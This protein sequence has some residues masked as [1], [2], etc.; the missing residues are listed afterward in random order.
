MR[1]TAISLGL[2][3]ALASGALA[4]T[5]LSADQILL[6]R[7]KERMRQNLQR[8]PNYTCVE[9]IQRSKRQ[10]WPR[11]LSF[12]DSL[13][14]EV[15]L[16]DGKELFSWPGTGQFE[17]KGLGELV[18]SG[19]TT[20]GDFALHARTVFFSE[21]PTFQYAGEESMASRRAVRF[22][23]RVSSLIS[24]YRIQIGDRGAVAGSFGSFWADRESLDLIR[25]DVHADELPAD[26][27]VAEATTEVEYGRVQV[28]D[29]DFL[30]PKTVQFVLRHDSG[31]ESRNRTAFSG[32][33]QYVAQSEI[34]FA[35]AAEHP[36]AGDGPHSGKDAGIGLPAGLLLAVRLKTPIDAKKSAG[37]PVA[38][39]LERAVRQDGKLLLPRGALINGRIRRLEKY[40]GVSDYYVVGLEFFSV[41]SADGLVR[42]S[43]GI[44]EAGSPQRVELGSAGLR[45]GAST[46][47][48]TP[49]LQIV[50]DSPG[51]GA[52]IVPGGSLRL[53]PGFRTVWKT[54]AP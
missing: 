9:S 33:R 27:R 1:S 3:L 37:D 2:C 54:V 39:T 28:G 8:V 26:L 42:L 51:V 49:T 7:I 14:V 48:E 30:L 52:F 24:D 53:L 21:A 16:V 34:S 35:D 46:S 20:T 6:A 31:E 22:D 25:L 11:G 5:G 17:E 4:Q 43:A 18:G 23:Y 19:T 10:P 13:R 29:S 40:G 32:C 45:G 47:Y 15:A 36:A 50:S 41:E 38:A 44:Q 12:A